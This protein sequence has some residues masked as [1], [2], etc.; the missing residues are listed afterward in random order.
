MV[1]LLSKC[2][3]RRGPRP[4]R[5]SA[6][7]PNRTAKQ[8]G[9]PRRVFCY[10]GQSRR[11]GSAELAR[12]AAE[13]RHRWVGR[14]ADRQQPIR[15]TSPASI[16]A[17]RSSSRARPTGT[18]P[19]RRGLVPLPRLQVADGS[20]GRYFKAPPQRAN[21]HWLKV[22]LLHHYGEQFWSG[23]LGLGSECRTLAGRHRLLSR[24]RSPAS[25]VRAVLEGIR[26]CGLGHQGRPNQARSRPRGQVAVLGFTAHRA[27]RLLSLVVRSSTA[28]R[29][30]SSTEAIRSD[31]RHLEASASICADH[32]PGEAVGRSSSLNGQEGRPPSLQAAI[33]TT[34]PSGTLVFTSSERSPNTD[35]SCSPGSG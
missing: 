22:E 6:T 29:A 16:V 27:P 24:P 5:C 4:A 21:R 34:L 12:S 32:A 3:R 33:D 2:W 26:A 35:L 20:A 23:S 11:A 17:R 10:H 14:S 9:P 7:P 19:C 28:R 1:E 15:F 30:R 31:G 13:E 8:A 18:P 25:E